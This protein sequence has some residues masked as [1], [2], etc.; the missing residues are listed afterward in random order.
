[1]QFKEWFQN[2]L[3]VAGYP[4]PA[5]FKEGNRYYKTD[6]VINVSDEY[7]KDYYQDLMKKGYQCYWFPMNEARRDIG[8]NS[9]YAALWVMYE[10][11][12]KNEKVLL[13]CHAGINRSQSVRAAY[14][15]MRTGTHFENP[16][17]K[18]DKH[19]NRLI[20]NCNRGYLPPL[21]EMETFLN[22]CGKFFKNKESYFGGCL[23]EIK[24][25][26]I[27]NF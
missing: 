6:V 16:R 8:L 9:I 12:E 23:D 10:A 1:M 26:S 17:N 20:A 25:K 15:Y 19:L 18:E 5:E 14:Y 11:E 22:E 4:V 27:N 7:M 2:K 3:V 13:H 21:R 24:K